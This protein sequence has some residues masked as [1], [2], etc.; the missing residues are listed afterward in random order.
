MH[1]VHSMVKINTHPLSENQRQARQLKPNEITKGKPTFDTK[2]RVNSKTP[3]CGV[4]G[5]TL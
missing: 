4:G 5:S 2:L 3:E 1:E